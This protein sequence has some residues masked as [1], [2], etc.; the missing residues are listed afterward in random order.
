VRWIAE[1]QFLKSRLGYAGKL[2]PQVLAGQLW[3]KKINKT[4]QNKTKQ[5]KL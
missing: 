2:A 1:W 5:K 4:K 3:N